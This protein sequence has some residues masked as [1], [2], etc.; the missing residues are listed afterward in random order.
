[1]KFHEKGWFCLKFKFIAPFK[2]EFS[3][4]TFKV[5]S[6]VETYSMFWGIVKG[7]L[8]ERYHDVDFLHHINQSDH[9]KFTVITEDAN[10][11]S[12]EV[13]HIKEGHLKPFFQQALRKLGKKKGLCP[14]LQG[15]AYLC[16]SC[17]IY[18]NNIGILE[19]DIETS[20]ANDTLMDRVEELQIFSNEL[21]EY[22]LQELYRDFLKHLFAEIH[23]IDK[24][25]NYIKN[26]DLRSTKRP[27]I[28]W[29]NRSLYI[30]KTEPELESIA[31]NWLSISNHTVEKITTE[32]NEQ[33]I[34]LGWGHN[35]IYHDTH[36]DKIRQAVEAI[37]LCQY[38]NAV[39][40]NFNTEL[41]KL[42]GESFLSNK[43]NKKTKDLSRKLNDMLSIT[44][45]LLI[46]L[47]EAKFNLQDY[48][49]YYFLDLVEKWKIEKIRITLEEKMMFCQEKIQEIYQRQ[50]KR[51]QFIMEIIL[52]SIGGIALVEFFTN[53]SQ[54]AF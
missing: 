39:L 27:I 52:F 3:I 14:V 32:L 49:Q 2:T 40:E 46:Q 53:I 54:F 36:V 30:S 21:M 15:A 50:S 35:L 10:T 31:E 29:V 8:L 47:N 37:H 13:L 18:D 12:A 19:L 44:K 41:T 34:Y 5:L 24:G 33:G 23:K 11:L 20:F 4:H 45:L 48:K 26:I 42:I 1:M 16:S 28:L 51:N 43:V 7:R 9:Q 38:F 17:K 6:N 25:W 22:T